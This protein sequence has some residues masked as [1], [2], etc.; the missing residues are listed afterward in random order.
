[1]MTRYRYELRRGDTITA[2]G[3]I[4]YDVPL[5]VGDKIT[6]GRAAGIVRELGPKNPDGESTLLIQLL[7]DAPDDRAE[8][9]RTLD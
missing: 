6:I 1:M 3:H 2:T 5:N 4:T 8:P 7:P 9:R